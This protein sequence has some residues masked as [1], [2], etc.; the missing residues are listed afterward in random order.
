MVELRYV[1]GAVVGIGRGAV[2]PTG[3]GLGITADGKCTNV[4]LGNYSSEIV[5]VPYGQTYPRA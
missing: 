3:P 1:I 4:E 5:R 2:T